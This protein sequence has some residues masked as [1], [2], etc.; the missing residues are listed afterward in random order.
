MKEEK[1]ILLEYDVEKLYDELQRDNKKQKRKLITRNTI[2]GT[3]LIIIVLLLLRGCNCHCCKCPTNTDIENE[4]TPKG[5][6]TQETDIDEI[7]QKD[8][9][10]KIEELNKKLEAGYMTFSINSS[11]VF[12]T[13]SSKGNLNIV[14]LEENNLP[15]VWQLW[16][17]KTNAEGEE[18]YD[19]MILETGL[20]PV[21]KSLPEKELD[22]P[23]EKGTHKILAI[24]Y[25]VNEDG[26]IGGMV[27]TYLN[28]TVKN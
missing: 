18:V 19:E 17:T 28:L 3:L 10:A 25:G 13:G 1:D 4:N 16:T 14:N 26:S 12:E 8:E 27:Q 20:I 23:L 6:Y 15:Q 9:Q 2:I 21:G 7:K 11:P 24:C 5:F 22:V